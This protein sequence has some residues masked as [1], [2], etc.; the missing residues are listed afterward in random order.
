MSALGDVRTAL[1]ALLGTATGL[2]AI[3]N[4]P[5]EI[6]PGT[7]YV[8]PHRGR[9]YIDAKDEEIAT[10]THPAVNMQAVIVFPPIDVS[11]VQ[12]KL[13]EYVEDIMQGFS[14]D[15]TLGQLVSDLTLSQVSEPGSIIGE[16]LGVE[17]TIA[18]FTV[19]AL[20]KD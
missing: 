10:F 19:N 5:S 7:I 8:R 12:N 16:L 3:P 2:T 1:A 20:R 13:D 14:A 6:R 15:P 9:D 18:A 17:I 11:H 4:V